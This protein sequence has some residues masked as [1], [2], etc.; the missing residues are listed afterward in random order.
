MDYVAFVLTGAVAGVCAGL[1]G[2]GGGLIIV[3]ILIWVFTYQGMNGDVIAHVALGTSLA[4]IILTSISSSTAHHKKGNVCWPIVKQMAMGLV[5]GSL[6]GA[7][8]AKQLHSNALQAV[9]GVGAVLVAF[10]MLSNSTPVLVKK[11]PQEQPWLYGGAGMGIGLMSAIFGIGGGSLTV[12]FLSGRGLLMKRAVGTSAACG[13]FIAVAGTMGF[14][15]FGQG[16]ATG[17]N[18]TVGFVHLVGFFCISVASV[19]T[20][21]LGASLA[22]KLPASQLKKAF[23][24]L[25][26]LVGLKMAWGGLILSFH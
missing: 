6:L 18:G 19:V 12:P 15:L 14:V 21:R 26:L 9:I 3:P 23:G 25:L 13:F 8:V 11:A 24:V 17:V 10:K 2:I 16:V 7:M 1:F 22:S 20:A 4:T 5:V